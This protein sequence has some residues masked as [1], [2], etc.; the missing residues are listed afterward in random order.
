MAEPPNT[1]RT[2]DLRFGRIRPF[3]GKRDTLEKFLEDVQLHLLLNRI[4]D[5]QDKIAFALTN[6]EGGDADSW[7]TAFIKKTATG[8]VINFGTWK[9][10]IE[11]LRK[12]FKPY[13]VQGEAID[14]IKTLKQGTNSIEDHVARFKVLLTNTGVDEESPAALDYFQ[15]SIR[16]P[17]VRKI[18]DLAE[19]PTTLESGTNG[20]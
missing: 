10:F 4:T 5:N 16:T 13:D 8:D 15:R 2:P 6:M 18:M 14:E 19:P 17:L 1:T 9:Q 3:A 20:P 12:N 7:R 11:D